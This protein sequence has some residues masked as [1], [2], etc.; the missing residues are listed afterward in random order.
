MGANFTVFL[1]SAGYVYAMGDNRFG[2]LGV[3]DKE[4]RARP[5]LVK[6]LKK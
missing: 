2:Q 1:S 6:T 4:D 5:T 3:G